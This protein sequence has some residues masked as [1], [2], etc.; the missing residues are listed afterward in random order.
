MLLHEIFNDVQFDC[1]SSDGPQHSKFKVQAMVTNK[2][3]EGTGKEVSLLQVYLD[4]NLIYCI[5]PSKKAA[6][7]AAAKAALASLC[8]ISYSPLQQTAIAVPKQ[9][10]EDGKDVELPQTF[11]DVIGK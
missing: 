9:S 6:K 3:F 5:G 11:A 10:T 8:N 2:K 4:V 7:N 1:L